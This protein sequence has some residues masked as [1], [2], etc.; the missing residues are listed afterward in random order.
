MELESLFTSTKWNILKEISLKPQSPMQ[1]AA[2]LNTSIANISQQ[3]RL[4]EAAGIVKKNRLP[5]RDRGKPRVIFSLCEDRGYII[6]TMKGFAEKKLLDLDTHQK[7][8][9]KVWFKCDKSLHEEL[10]KFYWKINE[11]LGDINAIATQNDNLIVL[12]REGKSNS[13]SKIKNLG[14]ELKSLQLVVKDNVVDLDN[15]NVL[16]DPDLFLMQKNRGEFHEGK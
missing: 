9:L 14:S 12:V 6:A 2:K 15:L 8:I 5:Q 3:I 11:F 10:E 13:V 16:Y 7:Y 1:L 4:L